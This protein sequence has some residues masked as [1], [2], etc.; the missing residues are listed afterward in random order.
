MVI[1][2][3]DNRRRPWQDL[4]SEQDYFGPVAELNLNDREAYFGDG[5][6]I[7]PV[8]E[9]SPYVNAALRQPGDVI[10]IC[11]FLRIKH[12]RRSLRRAWVFGQSAISKSADAEARRAAWQAAS[13]PGDSAV[14]RLHALTDHASEFKYREAAVSL[15]QMDA[16]YRPDARL[17]FLGDAESTRTNA[18][19]FRDQIE[20][21]DDARTPAAV[22]AAALTT[23]AD[24]Y[25][26][27]VD[28]DEQIAELVRIKTAR[29]DRWP[30]AAANPIGN[31]SDSTSI[32]AGTSAYRAA[33]RNGRGGR[34][35]G[36]RR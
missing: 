5:I 35:N 36:T 17:D 20:N 22:A 23:L 29:G 31:V 7:R 8:D 14:N 2:I 10:V 15:V 19:A 27:D 9:F 32:G 11:M 28:V 6:S 3:G 34:A 16:A 24:M 25:R 21:R 12:W 33:R 1:A 4:V 18:A 30:P 26:A 13:P